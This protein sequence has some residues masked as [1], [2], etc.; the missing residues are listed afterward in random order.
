M[1]VY[2]FIRSTKKKGTA[3]LRFRLKDGNGFERWFKSNINVDIARFDNKKGSYRLPKLKA[4]AAQSQDYVNELNDKKQLDERI[5]VV[6]KAITA[7]FLAKGHDIRKEEFS[8]LVDTQLHPEKHMHTFFDLFDDYVTAN[9]V[10]G[11][12]ISSYKQCK[13]HLMRFEAYK[14]IKDTSFKLD[15]TTF[16]TVTMGEFVNFLKTENKNYGKDGK[17]LPEFVKLY[18]RFPMRV[19]RLNDHTIFKNCN[20]LKIVVKWAFGEGMTDR[21]LLQNF[22]LKKNEYADPVFLTVE[23]RDKIASFDF[24]DETTAKYRD[25]F[26]FQC[27]TGERISDLMSFKVKNVANGWLTYIPI[28]TKGESQKTIRVPLNDVAQGIASKYSQGKQS[29]SKLFDFVGAENTYNRR[30]RKILT[31]CGINR[32]VAV[33]DEYGNADEKPLNEVA[34]SHIARKTFVGNLYKKTHDPNLISKMSGHAENS[35][36]FSRYRKICDDD[37]REVIDLL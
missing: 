17:P 2:P 7:V 15:V 30:L 5:S 37:L 18:E 12:Y 28:K 13:R 10:G 31:E 21:Y 19:H 1:R 34:G 29:D 16:D 6:T 23:E 20:I 27:L 24:T 22:K 26:I 14:Q 25:A 3:T 36:A 32:L 9:N 11:G 35:K 4:G 33:T 8:T